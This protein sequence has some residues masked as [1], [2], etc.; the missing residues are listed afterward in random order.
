MSGSLDRE[1][2]TSLFDE[3]SEELRF[4]R[5]RAHIYLIGGA[6]MSMAFSRERTTGDVG[7]LRLPGSAG[8]AG[9]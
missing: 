7:G 3:L 1:R 4:T 6:A 8:A 5:T 2:L 9:P